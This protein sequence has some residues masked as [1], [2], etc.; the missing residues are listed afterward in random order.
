MLSLEV[1]RFIGEFALAIYREHK[2]LMGS[3]HCT[4]KID[5]QLRVALG[6]AQ[7]D[8]CIEVESKD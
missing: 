7:V 1:Y 2:G 8:I 4:Y 6:G 3:Y 5:A